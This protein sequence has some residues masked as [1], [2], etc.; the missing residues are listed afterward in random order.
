MK[1]IVTLILCMALLTALFAG[2]G[3]TSSSQAPAP[4]PSSSEP[5]P[6]PEQGAALKTG[7]GVVTSLG[8]S[9]DAGEKDGLAQ[10]DSV[11]VA[12]T[13][14]ADGKIVA[15]EIDT[16]QNKISFSVEGK[17]VT[18]MD[19]VFLSKQELKLDYGMKAASGIEKE[20]FEQ[21]DALAAYV[22]GKT[23]DEVKG[24][25]LDENA[26]PTD[27]ELLTSVTM[28]I[29]GYLSAIEK[30]VANAQELGAT[31]GD[32]LG[33][34]IVTNMVQ[35]K[36]AGEKDGLAQAYSTYAAVT[37]N[38]DGVITSYVSDA[39][40]G[41]VN[42]DATGKITTDLTVNPASKKEL[43]EEYGMKVASPI[44][45]EWFEQAAAFEQYVTGKT[46]AEVKGTALDE[47][48]SAAD[49]E[50]L[51]SVTMTIDN[52]ILS[53]EKAVANAR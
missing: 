26:M 34:G 37:V 12:V 17:L 5:A 33:L 45:K 27:E 21:A 31:A 29:A 51:T 16:A 52:M 11:V 8:S 1:K 3:G 43:G 7:L 23:M 39:S 32:K 18:P 50:M 49:A 13:V 35:S 53:V 46:V 41:N 40:Q 10:T 47:A 48:G 30:A 14:D 15:C 44:G 9:K 38:A 22:V 4:A 36:D 20:W 42:F 6:A 28:K 2:C 25:A 24:I 19:T